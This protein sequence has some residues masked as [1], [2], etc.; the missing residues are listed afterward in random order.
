[1]GPEGQGLAAVAVA[2][3]E[4]LAVMEETVGRRAQ[5]DRLEL[6][7]VVVRPELAST[8]RSTCLRL[9]EYRLEGEDLHQE[10]EIQG[11]AEVVRLGI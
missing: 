8:H 1:M 5:A 4:A 10:Q 2:A 6:E 3:A 9:A 11:A 7:Q